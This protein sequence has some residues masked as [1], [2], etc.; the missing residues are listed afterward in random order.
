MVDVLVIGGGIV[1]ASVAAQ[2]ARRGMS[3]VLC[4]RHGLA[5]GAS[6][7]NAGFVVGPHPP[8]LE[9]IAAR[10]LLE[11]LD[12]HERSGRAFALDRASIGSLVV[13]ESA[14]ELAG[15]AGERLD[16]EALRE[17]EP[18][19][20]PDLAGAVLIEARRVDPGAA[21]AAWAEEARAH[22]AE[23]RLGCEVRALLRDGDVV[24][25]ALTDGGRVLAGTTVI[26]A[27]PWSS[28]LV[29]GAGFDVPVRG[30]RGWV[31]ITRPAPFRLDRIIEDASWPAGAIPPITVRDLALGTLPAPGLSTAFGQDD[32]GR[33]LIGASMQTGTGDRDE[34]PETLARVCS[35]ALRFL[36]A[37]ATVEV[38]ETRSCLRPMTPDGLPLHGPV[39]GVERLVLACGHNAQGVTWGPGAAASVADGLATGVWD[40]ALAP[41]RFPVAAPHG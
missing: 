32:D 39:P 11:Y 20:A 4:E 10:S 15:H 22:G 17:L 36:P 40:A 1:G 2:C 28:R 27:G 7:R 26:A 30:V 41:S 3:V 33:V 24:R 23:I 19:L 35:R 6:G 9:A 16:A 29:R 31:A 14:D 13:A 18:M 21:T 12:L 34:A 37:L 25:G 8:Q 38:A 5:A